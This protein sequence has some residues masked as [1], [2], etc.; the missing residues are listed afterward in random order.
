MYIK[1]K[2]RVISPF[3]F[4]KK[5]FLQI[6]KKMLTA[7]QMCVI[8]LNV[9]SSTILKMY[10]WRRRMIKIV[11]DSTTDLP[12]DIR[13]RVTIVPL[14][15]SFSGEQFVD[16]LDI[17]KQEFYERLVECTELPTTSQPSP[18]SFEGVFK[19]AKK[20]GDKVV[21]ITLS[22]KLSGTYQSAKI[23]MEGYEDTVSLIDSRSAA[24][25]TG[26]LVEMAVKMAE[27]GESAERIAERDNICVV[28]MLD[29][30]EYLKKGGRISRLSAF[31]GGILSI[32]PVIC[33]R[34]GEIEI[35]GKAR[36]SKNGNNLLIKEIESAGG[37]DFTKPL[38]LGYTGLSDALLQ[39][40]IKDSSF[41]W[42][43]HLDELRTVLVGSVIGTHIGPGGIAVAFFKKS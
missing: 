13:K 16:G 30:L 8:I 15:I 29:T 17:S 5:Y 12:K 34:N 22:S 3:L 10:I 35:L 28:A 18:L 21:C 7:Q 1:N 19:D 37:V 33:I 24:I 4:P 9:D 26:I 14:I 43:E 20:K 39:K 27:K 23:A 40:Y 41:L 25:G 36:G 31:A 38:L 6:C 2:E 32:K 11:T 42:D